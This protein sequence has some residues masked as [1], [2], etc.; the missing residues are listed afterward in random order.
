M[1]TIDVEALKRACREDE[2]EVTLSDGR[3]VRREDE[4]LFNSCVGCAF[5]HEVG[6]YCE[7]G[8]RWKEV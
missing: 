3:T 2:Y 8:E 6:C 7:Y 4:I 5:S 1:K